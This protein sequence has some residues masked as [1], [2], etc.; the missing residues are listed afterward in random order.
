M[1]LAYRAD[2]DGLRAI[3]VGS[4]VL[5]HG[6]IPPF[7]GGYV[8]VDVFFVISGFLITC[9]LDR[10]ITARRFSLVDFYDHR[11]RRILPALFVVLAVVTLLA[12]LILSPRDMMQYARSLGPSALFYAN[13]H[14]ESVLDYF[15]PRAD[16]VP[17][18]HLWSLAVEEQFY[19]LF[20][21]LLYVLMRFGTRTFA[22]AALAVLTVASLIHSQITVESQPWTAFFLLPSRAWELFAG[23]LIA[24]IRWP[25]I[26]ARAAGAIALAGVAAILA[27]VF[28]YDRDTSFPGLSALPPVLGSAAI[29]FAGMYTQQGV[30]QKVLGHPWF[31]YVGRISYSL[32]LWHWPLLVLAAEYKGRHLTYLQAGGIILV[33][34][35]LSA[36]SLKFVETPLRRPSVLGGIRLARFGAGALAIALSFGV[37]QLIERTGGGFRSLSARAQAAEDAAY[38][39][40]RAAGRNA[41]TDSRRLWVSATPAD[42]GCAFSPKSTIAPYDVAVWGDSHAGAFNRGLSASLEQSGYKVRLLSMPACPPIL[43][44]TATQPRYPAQACVNFNNAVLDELRRVRPKAVILV[45]RW[46]MWT[47]LAGRHF[48]LTTPDIPGGEERSAETTVRAF[49]YGIAH[50]VAALEAIGANVIVVG[51]PPEF[52]IAPTECAIRS[53]RQGVA[54]GNC[55]TIPRAV[56]LRA[57]SASN[58][59]LAR[60]AAKQPRMSLFL[61]SD[62]FCD[63]TEC[64]G[65]KGGEFYFIDQHHLAQHGAVLAVNSPGFKAALEKALGPPNKTSSATH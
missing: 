35:L 36:L 23:S 1:S 47:S 13:I 38:S 20:P 5:F 62:V 41:C 31:T 6:H 55:D 63:E 61:L 4:V 2:I 44:V 45:S 15:G 32:Y 34:I 24:L 65:A 42:D 7:S 48:W 9:I 16:S 39:G 57:V 50:T 14:F 25:P 12:A 33:S 30:V 11:I 49:N 51:Q 58:E 53:E 28:L 64:R 8:G 17:L 18:L 10:E 56:G 19:I 59:L 29:I 54:G 43:G 60:I 37:V 3:A 21:V 22:V 27:P 26:P 46:A 52:P 40:A